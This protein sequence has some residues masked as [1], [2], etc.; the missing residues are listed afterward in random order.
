M[1]FE[2]TPTH[3][4]PDLHTPTGAL[5]EDVKSKQ[6]VP[7]EGFLQLPVTISR[8]REDCVHDLTDLLNFG[9]DRKFSN[10]IFS[11]SHVD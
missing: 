9:L 2:C 3:T 6:Q 5:G 4:G 11:Y 10:F 8:G 1:E 7:S